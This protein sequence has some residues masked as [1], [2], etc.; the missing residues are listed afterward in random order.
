MELV[1][2]FI[3]NEKQIE[4]LRTKREDFTKAKQKEIA[5]VEYDVYRPKIRA[6]MDE[7]DNKMK[8]LRA[9]QEIKRKEID[10]KIEGLHEVIAKVDR[11]LGFLKLQPQ[12][13]TKDLEIK[14]EEIRAYHDKHIESLGYIFNDK[15][16]K[17]KL[18]IAENSKPKN[19][20]SLITVGKC[21]FKRE[22][23]GLPHSYG[24]PIWNKGW[25]SLEIVIKDLPTTQELRKY[26]QKRK[27]FI[28]TLSLGKYAA[29]KQEYLR[30]IRTYK[31][32]DFEELIEYR[33]KCGFFY[34]KS[35]CSRMSMREE[36]VKCSKC[37]EEMEHVEHAKSKAISH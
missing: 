26:L 30:C 18:F 9:E 6:L 13:K 16:L 27:K 25:A 28:L 8:T 20:Y 34:S 29:V 22:L 3:E 23:A 21:L 33:C 17:I 19:K 4:A 2:Q 7:R 36:G 12:E 1:K 35:E 10:R 5:R 31:I 15:F 24:V 37:A 11:I 32:K 14:D